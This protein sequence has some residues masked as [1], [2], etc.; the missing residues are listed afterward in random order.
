MRTMRE[1]L[2]LAA[3]IKPVNYAAVYS[4]EEEITL[5]TR[6]EHLIRVVARLK[7]IRAGLGILP[8]CRHRN[9]TLACNATS[10][11]IMERLLHNATLELQTFTATR[12]N[13]SA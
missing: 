13:L 4:E 5:L 8:D 7:E 12:G 2:A 6:C 11:V 10:L 1:S 3:A 9:D